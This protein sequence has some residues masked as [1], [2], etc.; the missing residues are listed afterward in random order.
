MAKE[1]IPPRQRQRQRRRTRRSRDRALL[2][3]GCLDLV[4]LVAA[5]VVFVIL[6]QL[7]SER[8]GLPVVAAVPDS[9][10]SLEPPATVAI[11]PVVSAPTRAPTATLTAIPSAT[12]PPVPALNLA[13]VF[14]SRSLAP[15]R[16]DPSRLRVVI[17]TGDVVPA[18][19]TDVA[20]RERKDDFL[21]PIAK[22]KDVLAAGDLTIADL[23]AA[24]IKDC[25]YHDSGFKMCGRP[26]FVQALTMAG[27]D[28]ATMEN[29]HISNYGY[30]GVVE[31]RKHLENAAIAWVNRDNPVMRDV[32]GLKFGILAFNGVGEKF[33][34]ALIAQ[35]IRDWRA[36]VDVVIVALHWGKEYESTPQIAPGIADDNPV[37]IAHLAVDAGAD[38]ILGN[39][40]H[41]VQ[42][43]EIYKGKFIAYAHGNFIFDQMWSDETRIGVIGKYTFYDRTLVKV[44][45]IPTRI[46]DYA[47][48]VPLSGAEAQAALDGMKAASDKIAHK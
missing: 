2:F 23:E 29:N 11:L 4:L 13:D 41:W 24:L 38:L 12:L 48:P 19:S 1:P 31:T 45:F 36:K 39:H 34:R 32:R 37:E 16:L 21:F 20:I 26:G 30:A 40:P 15:F 27:V 42:G 5:V 33:D 22:T 9:P 8:Q 10:P 43:V 18:R 7:I 35:Q 28:I 44:E 25:P 14:P 46:E 17:A 47:Q 6:W 3:Y